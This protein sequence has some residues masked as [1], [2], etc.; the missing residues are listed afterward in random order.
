MILLFNSLPRLLRGG[1]IGEKD[2]FVFITV[3]NKRNRNS[4]LYKLICNTDMLIYDLKI[5]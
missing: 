4:Y 5:M 1:G 2:T 3:F